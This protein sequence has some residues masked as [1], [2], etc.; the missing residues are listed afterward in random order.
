MSRVLNIP[1]VG[2]NVDNITQLQ[3]LAAKAFLIYGLEVPNTPTPCLMKRLMRDCARRC[4]NLTQRLRSALRR[5]IHTLTD[6]HRY[7]REPPMIDEDHQRRAGDAPY[8]SSG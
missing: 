4:A 2:I 5:F 7:M 3:Y 6:P 1:H 8:T